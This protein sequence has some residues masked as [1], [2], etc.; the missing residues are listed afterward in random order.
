MFHSVL[1][2]LVLIPHKEV[3]HDQGDLVDSCLY[4]NGHMD[5]RQVWQS[6]CHIQPASNCAR[7]CESLVVVSNFECKHKRMV[8]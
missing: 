2:R 7:I 8:V 3:I 1:N 5:M 6:E 4:R